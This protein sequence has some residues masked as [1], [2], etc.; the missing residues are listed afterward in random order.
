MENA[1]SGKVMH[2]FEVFLHQ[3]KLLIPLPSNFLK[4]PLDAS[5]N[6][7]KAYSSHALLLCSACFP[8]GGAVAHPLGENEQCLEACWGVM[9]RGTGYC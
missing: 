6:G 8:T 5:R 4:Y 9:A 3:N 2:W 7:I 1:C